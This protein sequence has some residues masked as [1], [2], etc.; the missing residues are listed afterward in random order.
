M[1]VRVC[2]LASYRLKFLSHR[3]RSCNQAYSE[4]FHRAQ[5]I[6]N[7]RASS[8][9]PSSQ[10]RT[11]KGSAESCPSS[12]RSP[13]LCFCLTLRI[14]YRFIWFSGVDYHVSPSR[15]ASYFFSCNIKAPPECL[16]AQGVRIPCASSPTPILASVDER[17]LRRGLSPSYG[18]TLRALQRTGSVYRKYH[19]DEWENNS[20]FLKHQ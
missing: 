13:V 3:C 4:R 15:V 5:G 19:C 18:D 2:K 17:R 6:Q 20:Y 16:Q 14:S 12:R 11:T 7:P 1:H 9:T 10:A 8:S